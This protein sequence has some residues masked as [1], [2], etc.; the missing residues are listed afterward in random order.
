MSAYPADLFTGSSLGLG[1]QLGAAAAAAA[2]AAA[3]PWRPV[4]MP[5]SPDQR[6]RHSPLQSSAV[7]PHHH[8]WSQTSAFSHPAAAAGLTEG[9]VRLLSFVDIYRY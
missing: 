7:S 1:Y 6:Y 2:A 3:S 5:A 8:L 4:Y 9:P